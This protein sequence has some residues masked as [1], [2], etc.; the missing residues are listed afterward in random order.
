MA[1]AKALLFDIGDVVMRSNWDMLDLLERNTG[2]T[3]PGRGPLDPAGDPDW[4]RYLDG[5]LAWNDYW[6]HKAT[7]GG[8]P[9]RYE[10]W[11]DMC[12]R[13][14]EAQFDP[15]ALALIDQ[16]RVAGVLVGVLS[17]D[18]VAIGG[19]EW[20]ATRPELAG[21]DAFVDAT[22]L[23]ERKPAAAPYL[24]AIEQFGVAADDIV[25]LDDTV[26]C[27]EGARA[28]GMIGVHVD[29]TDKRPAFGLARQLV[30][31]VPPSAAQAMVDRAEAAYVARDLDA[32]MPL[33]H[34]D[35]VVYWNGQIVAAGAVEIRRLLRERLGF[36]GLPRPGDRLRTSLRAAVGD[37]V[38]VEWE[39]EHVDPN[40]GVV[41]GRAADFWIIR[42]GRII[43]WMA[44]RP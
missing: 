26:A 6:E 40:G 18:L 17:N 29:P 19:S 38:C 41:R 13:L 34:P 33:F 30:G 24:A 21:Y 3:I 16:A 4:A 31:L 14:D 11:R 28:V 20:V 1:R 2:R 5:A 39:S 35:A 44:Y 37:T 10:M 15:D 8:Y 43:E 12:V 22:V 25:F 27:V 9:G 32:A 7:A 36:D 42:Y 23:G